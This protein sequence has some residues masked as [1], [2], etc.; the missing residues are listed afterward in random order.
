MSQASQIDKPL[1]AVA[2]ATGFVGSHL[3]DF[4]K[5]DYR[6]RALTRSASVVA[7][8]PSAESTEWHRCDLY[9]LPKVT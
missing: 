9:S 2:G 4:L 3:R 7:Q 6:F 5:S 1:V 8:Y